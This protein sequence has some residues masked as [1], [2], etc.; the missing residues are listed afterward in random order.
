MQLA[1]F[2]NNRLWT[3]VSEPLARLRKKFKNPL[4]GEATTERKENIIHV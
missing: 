3:D 2:K 1:C 4:L